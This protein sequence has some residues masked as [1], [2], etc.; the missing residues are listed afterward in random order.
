[1]RSFAKTTLISVLILGLWGRICLADRSFNRSLDARLS[2]LGG[3]GVAL[4]NLSSSLEVN[5]GEMVK[6]DYSKFTVFY[7]NLENELHTGYSEY[8]LPLGSWFSIGAGTTLNFKDLDQ[9]TQIYRFGASMDFFDRVSIGVSPNV[10]VKKT[11]DGSGEEF[12]IDGGALL[13]PFGWMDIG[14]AAKDINY[15]Q[16][17]FEQTGST[18]TFIGKVQ[19][20]VSIFYP[21]YFN[22]VAD[23]FVEDFKEEYG[24]Y[25]INEAF[26]IEI[27]PFEG[28][29]LRGGF[30]ADEWQMGLG[31]TSRS[32]DLSYS[33]NSNEKF[34]H[35]IQYTRKFGVAPSIKE[36]EIRDRVVKVGQDE[37]YLKALTHYNK[38][39]I[40]RAIEKK[41]KYIQLYGEDDRI[42]QFEQDIKY[43][44]AKNRKERLEQAEKLENKVLEY[45][46]KGLIEEAVNELDNIKVLAP[47]YSPIAYLEHLLK[48]R[49]LLEEGKYEQAEQEL[50]ESLKINPDGEHVPALHRRLQEVLRLRE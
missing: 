34:E 27:Y 39:E 1:M 43:W 6:S 19:G 50:V 49:V 47:A 8:V 42:L 40:A 41:E 16:M 4:K 46:H 9:F 28:L 13:S 25:R 3:A 38:D 14:I 18:L 37:L 10:R 26:G 5:P 2:G 21:G 7:N 29:A 20:G 36:K 31:I 24:N 30:G 12:G 23:I 11:L 22:I 17:N 35:S 44:L 32:V 33:Y 45:Y 48:A 15:P